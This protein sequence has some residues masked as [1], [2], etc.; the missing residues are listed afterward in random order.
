[1]TNHQDPQRRAS[2]L[3]QEAYDAILRRDPDAARLATMAAEAYRQ[4]RAQ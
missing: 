4:E 1:M 3:A 2:T